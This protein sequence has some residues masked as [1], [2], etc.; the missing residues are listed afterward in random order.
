MSEEPIKRP[1]MRF[2][3]QV[4]NGADWRWCPIIVAHPAR[5]P[6]IVMPDGTEQ[7]LLKVVPPNPEERT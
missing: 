6:Y 3:W 7:E 2:L 1:G 4:P 5:P